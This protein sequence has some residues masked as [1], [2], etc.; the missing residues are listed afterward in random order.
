MRLLAPICS[1]SD[2]KYMMHVIIMIPWGKRPGDFNEETKTN[3]YLVRIPKNSNY[4]G[5]DFCYP[6]TLKAYTHSGLII[7]PYNAK[8][9]PT[10]PSFIISAHNCSILKLYPL[11]SIDILSHCCSQSW[12]KVHVEIVVPKH[13][14]ISACIT[15]LL[16]LLKYKKE[17]RTHSFYCLT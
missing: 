2:K 9:S 1:L 17:F 7:L 6:K 8:L 16:I 5:Q 12:Q 14:A 3:I 4:Q 11:Q 13:D 15:A 10:K